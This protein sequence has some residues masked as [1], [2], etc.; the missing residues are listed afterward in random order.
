MAPSTRWSSASAGNG[1]ICGAP[2]TD[3]GGEVLEILAQRRRDTQA[4]LWLMRKLLKKQGFAPKLLVTDKPRSIAVLDRPRHLYTRALLACHPDRATAFTGIPGAV[5]SPLQAAPGA[6]L[7]RAAARR[8]SPAH[9]AAPSSATEREGGST[10]CF[11]SRLKSSAHAPR[12][13]QVSRG[14]AGRPRV[15]AD[16]AATPTRRA[17]PPPASRARALAARPLCGHH[18]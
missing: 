1:C 4:A 14:A 2:L 8:A 9:C 15:R 12:C 11:T 7:R 10:A 18:G 17:R 13:A 5:P 3:R 6:V 16:N